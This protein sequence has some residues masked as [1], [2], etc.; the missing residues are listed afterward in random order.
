MQ[1]GLVG[2]KELLK[3]FRGL[4]LWAVGGSVAVPFAAALAALSPPWP[5]SIVL[6]TAVAELVA[7]IYVYQFLKK[8]KRKSINKILA[9]SGFFV[10]I[11]GAIYLVAISLYTYQVPT[12]KER[13]VKGY[14]CTQEAATVFKDK[15]PDLSLDQLKTAEYDADRLW[16]SRSIAVT[17]L[18]IVGLWL[19][20]FVAL[21]VLVGSFLV[22]QMAVPATNRKAIVSHT[23]SG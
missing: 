3:E 8:A 9:L 4:S 5:P 17:R 23:G 10:A 6:V 18:T 16:T 22:Y 19:A 14:R 20:A 2:F 7:L 21:S 13:F 12:T 11:F 15:C 1:S